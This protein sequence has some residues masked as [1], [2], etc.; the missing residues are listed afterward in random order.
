MPHKSVADFIDA[1]WFNKSQLNI[2]E[3]EV[4]IGRNRDRDILATQPIPNYDVNDFNE[5]ALNIKEL[6][7]T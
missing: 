3:L 1:G 5:M 4:T 6:A 7:R 2:K